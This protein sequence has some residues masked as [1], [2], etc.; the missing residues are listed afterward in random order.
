VLTDFSVEPSS[1]DDAAAFASSNIR[2]LQQNKHET[3]VKH[4]LTGLI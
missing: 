3:A 1:D 4:F 2:T